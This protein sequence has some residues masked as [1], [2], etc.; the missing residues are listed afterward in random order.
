MKKTIYSL[1]A[2]Q[3]LATASNRRYLAFVM[4]LEDLRASL[5]K[6]DR[7]TQKAVENPRSYRGSNFF[8]APDREV[9]ESIGQGEFCI[10]GMQNQTL[11]KWLPGRSTQQ[12]S[13]TIKRRRTHGL[14]K[15]TAERCAL[16]GGRLLQQPQPVG[17]RNGPHPGVHL[18][19][20]LK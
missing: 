18:F 11:R 17:P 5:E 13:R 7:V 16:A 2:L 4:Q 6:L 15:K 19:F 8:D 14:V 20:V 1:G 12:V 10:G 9:L 3:E